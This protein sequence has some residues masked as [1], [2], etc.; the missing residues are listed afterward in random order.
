M[1]LVKYSEEV[2]EEALRMI[3]EYIY[4]ITKNQVIVFPQNVE[5]LIDCSSQELLQMRDQIDE[6]LRRKEIINEM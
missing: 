3:T 1:I 2:S 4:T 5:V 6:V